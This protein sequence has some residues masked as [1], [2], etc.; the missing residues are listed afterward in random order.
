MQG[1]ESEDA[2]E[3]EVHEN[4]GGVQ[5]RILFGIVRVGVRI[6]ADE[7][8]IGVGVALA[9][10]ADEIGGRDLRL[11]VGGGQNVMESVTIPTAGGLLIAER[12]DLGVE[13]IAVGGIFVLVTVAAGGGGFDLIA[14]VADARDLVGGVAIGADRGF[15][16]SGGEHLAVD[17]G[18]VGG[19]G[20]TVAGA[21]GF[22]NMG[23]IG[24]AG[25]ILT[26]QNLVGAVTAGAAGGD[27]QSVFGEREAVNGIGVL[28]VD[29]GRV[30]LAAV[31]TFAAGA[32]KILGIS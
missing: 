27:E 16:D 9:A 3:Q 21:A 5:Q 19:F 20:S 28:G 30:A 26:R 22:R 18:F 2:G 12:G 31:V 29:G 14:D 32:G 23:A 24:A 8:R 11:G 10:G 17:S 25:G 15:L 1:E 6:V 13:G 7:A 4:G